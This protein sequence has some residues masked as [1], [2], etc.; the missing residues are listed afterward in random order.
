[1]TEKEYLQNLGADFD[2][3]DPNVTMSNRWRKKALDMAKACG[4]K[5][6]PEPVELPRL[7]TRP[8]SYGAF[9]ELAESRTSHTG[10]PTYVLTQAQADEII[11]RCELLPK[12]REY[13]NG[14]ILATP[15]VESG[16]LISRVINPEILDI[17]DGKAE[18]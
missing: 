16:G 13:L 15:L 3:K 12:L 4:A 7:T 1:M 11:R 9:V 14:I 6:D 5:F 10:S 2:S 17:I 8:R 18:W